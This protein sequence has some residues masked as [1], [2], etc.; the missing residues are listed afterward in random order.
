MP[1]V[2]LSLLPDGT[3]LDAFVY[4]H[5]TVEITGGR[6]ALAAIR[7]LVQRLAGIQ[8]LR[9]S[10]TMHAEGGS[11]IQLAQS[12]SPDSNIDTIVDDHIRRAR[13]VQHKETT[14][15][16]LVRFIE[17]LPVPVTDD[18]QW[19][20]FNGKELAWRRGLWVVKS[21]PAVSGAEGYQQPADQ[22]KVNLGPL[23]EGVWSVQQGEYQNI[24]NYPFRGLIAGFFSTPEAKLG[25]W[26]GSIIAWGVER[27]WVF[28]EKDTETYGRKDFSIHGGLFPGSAGCI[29][30]T[31]HMDAFT[32]MFL[33]HGKDMILLVD[34]GV[35][36]SK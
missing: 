9:Q 35:K 4:R 32:E 6:E 12:L 5:M 25:N 22:P 15:I 20:T 19:L 16:E 2:E 11:G 1:T 10:V 31:R 24:F 7:A 13:I 18:L 28:P 3:D 36:I 29:D 33:R 34:Y 8:G 14:K 17:R 27:V 21:W 26:P 23:P 30:M